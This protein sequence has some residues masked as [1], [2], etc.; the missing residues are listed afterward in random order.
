MK[1]F[2]V[3]VLATLLAVVSAVPAFAA[4][5]VSRFPV[6]FNGHPVAFDVQPTII[7]NRTFV[8]FRAIFEKMGADVNWDGD[9]QTITANRGSTEIKLTIGSATAYVNGEAKELPAAPFIESSRTLVPLRFVGEAFGA[10]VN[11]DDATTAISIVD[12]NWP[13]RGG[14]LNLALWNK[15]AGKFN[16]IITDETYTTEITSK[17]FDGLWRYDERVIPIP[18]MAEGWEWDESNTVLTFHLRND[19]KFHDGT[20]FTAKD[21][22]FTYKA[23]W[24]PKYVGPRNTGWEDVLGWEAYTKGQTGETAENFEKGFVTTDPLEGLYAPDD[25]TVVFKLKQPNAVFLEAVTYGILDHTKYLSVPVQD[26]GLAQDPN[27]AKPNGTGPF[28]L[29]SMVEGQNYILTANEDYFLGAPYIDRIIYRV[30]SSDVAVGE[31]QRGTLDMVEFNATEWD[32][33]KSLEGINLLE[34]PAMV[35]QYMGFNTQ[36]GA[37]ADKKVRQAIAYAID[38]NVIIHNLMNDHAS[39][40]YTPIHPLTWAF[41][42]EVEKYE[43]DLDK[44]NALLDEAGWTKGS[45]GIREKGGQKLHLRLVYPNVGNQ[46]RIRTAPVV[47]QMLKEIGV[48]VELVGYDFATVS[49]KVFTEYDFDLYFIG[50]SLAIDPDPSDLYGKKAAE[51]PGSFNGTRWWTPESEELLSKAKRTTDIDERIAYYTEW[52]KLFAEE[53]PAFLFYAPTTMEASSQRLMNYKPGVQGDWWNIEEV[54][55]AE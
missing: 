31:M 12:S 24:H 4:R 38:R 41:T 36:A 14:D 49:Q 28:K 19:I 27:T 34:F 8:P 42:D 11:Y 15:P 44:A 10:E 16:S 47:Q 50:M 1:R 13:K 32:A 53:L 21:V 45:D 29:E 43:F 54:W 9:T 48:E 33:Y 25:Y 23:I 46:V 20:P 40:L 55:L 7:N 30:L 3:F 17:V 18:A 2:V 39:A 6:T 5:P 37:T 52:Q 26:F 51:T 22:I 35:Y